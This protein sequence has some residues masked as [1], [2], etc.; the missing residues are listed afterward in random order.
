M[1][2]KPS[3]L[4]TIVVLVILIVLAII[5]N[6]YKKP[7]TST[8]QEKTSIAKEIYGIS[9]TIE[10]IRQNTLTAN[11]L[12]LLEDPTKQPISKKVNVSINDETKIYKLEFPDPENLTQEQI[13]NGVQPKETK[14]S[15]SDLKKGDT[16]DIR[17]GENVSGNIKNN[18]SF[19]ASVIN[20]VE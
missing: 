2:I 18:T 5:F 11:A 6:G 1:K 12:I 20:V 19:T 7:G 10:E 9:G 8:G 16:I 17:T 15:L 3:I 4:I 13:E 14:L